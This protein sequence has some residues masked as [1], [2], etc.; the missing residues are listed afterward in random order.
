M[1]ITQS[2]DQMVS[3]GS[4][5]A[6]SSFDLGMLQLALLSKDE[7]PQPVPQVFDLVRVAGRPEAFGQLIEILLFL[8]LGF[9]STLDEFH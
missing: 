6:C 9:N 4:R 8:L 2:R 1:A 5:K 3:N 7:P